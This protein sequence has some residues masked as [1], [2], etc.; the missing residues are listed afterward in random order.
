M[1]EDITEEILD[2]AVIED[3]K[4]PQVYEQP[5]DVDEKLHQVYFDTNNICVADM[6]HESLMDNKS[7]LTKGCPMLI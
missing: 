1:V 7:S 2:T 6:S 4:L 5:H 3:V